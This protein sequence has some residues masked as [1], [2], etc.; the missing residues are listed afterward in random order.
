M[1]TPIWSPVVTA[2]L[3]TI[4]GSGSLKAQAPTS[5]LAS[6]EPTMSHA[7]GTF[8]VTTT[9]QTTVDSTPGLGRMSIDKQYHGDLEG[10]GH[11]E[12][13]TGMTDVQ[14]S[15]AYV[16]IERF[17]GT[18]AGRRG[19]FLL[20]HRGTMTRGTQEL[21]II[22]VPDSGT[23]QLVGVSGTMMITI[24]GGRHSYALEYTLP[25]AQ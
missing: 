13:L 11:G 14:G 21:K 9:P 19:T 4:G 25:A 1:T 10:M 20:Q 22:I 2:L 23:G 16:A 6:R 24:V 17:T 15:A 18:L 8:D 12:M 7:R 5:P 3:L